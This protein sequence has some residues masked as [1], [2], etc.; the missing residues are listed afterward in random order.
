MEGDDRAEVPPEEGSD[1]FLYHLYRGSTMLLQ[2]QVV[3]AKH[4]LEQAL[5]LQPQDAKSQDLLAGV[6]FRLG[7]YPRSI[8]IWRR[9]SQ[10]YPSEVTLRVNLALALF[11]TGQGDE[12]L[13]HIHE[14]LRIQPDHERAWG[15]LGLILWRLGNL[16]EARNAFLRGGQATMARRMEAE[17]RQKT[18]PG[19]DTAPID[20]ELREQDRAA[21]RSAAEE[22]LERLEDEHP[23][24]AVEAARKRPKRDSVGP[25]SSME[26]GSELVPP[27]PVVLPGR[28]AAEPPLLGAEVGEWSLV[29]PPGTPLA[30][31]ASGV[32]LVQAKRDVYMRL[33]GLAACR[34]ELRTTVVMRRARGRELDEIL[35]RRDPIMHWRGAI[36]AVVRPPPGMMFLAVRLGKDSLYL[37][38]AFL[39]GFDDRVD[40]ESANLPLAGDPVVITQLHGDGIVVLQVPAPPIA[41]AVTE[42]EEVRVVPEQLLGWTGRLFPNAR[43]GTEPYSAHAPPLAFRGDGVVFLQDPVDP[44]PPESKKPPE[45]D[46]VAG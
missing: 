16:E 36:T 24:L 12:A 3:E 20:E 14:A 6:Y 38:E 37:R 17:L 45:K 29:L 21:M 19:H 27:K 40:Y 11:K 22:A 8:E 15:Y 39:C 10:A 5:A 2:D 4:E 1:D 7:L 42:G 26:P 46:D 32:L 25:W 35:G 9:L 18:L 43:R 34:G 41:L 33:S 44:P 13:A 30:I 31:S 23:H 28:A